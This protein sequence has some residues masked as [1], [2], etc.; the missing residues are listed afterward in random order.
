MTEEKEQHTFKGVLMGLIVCS[1]GELHIGIDVDGAKVAMNI[2]HAG[3]VFQQLGD[4]LEQAGYFKED[5]PE[6][7]GAT[8][9]IH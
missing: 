1:H 4:L 5:E 8:C 6:I 9:K 2:E 7:E 3:L